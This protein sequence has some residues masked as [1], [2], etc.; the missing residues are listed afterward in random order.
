MTDENS[1]S[2]RYGY[3]CPNCN[4]RT[5]PYV[6][7]QNSPYLQNVLYASYEE[8]RQAPVANAEFYLCKTCLYLFNP[9]FNWNNIQYNDQ[10]NNDQNHSLAYCDHMD[11]VT[12]F[13]AQFIDL[14]ADIS[15]L[16]IGCGNG[17]LLS[18]LNERGVSNLKGYDPSYQG[19]FGMNKY[20]T[21]EYWKCQQNEYFDVIIIRHTLEGVEDPKALLGQIK[22]ASNTNT[23]LY[24]EITDL[25]TILR[26]GKLCNLYHE[27]ARYFSLTSVAFLLTKFGYQIHGMKY[28]FAGN[29]L[30]V[31]AKR[32]EENKLPR[33]EL[34][35][36]NR[37][38]RILIWGIGGMSI[39]FLT[40][41][42]ISSAKIRFGVDIDKTKQHKYIPFTGQ[43]ILS[44]AEAVEYH[45]D[46]VIVLNTIYANEV[47]DVFDYDVDVLTAKD[48][49][50]NTEGDRK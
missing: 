17:Y 8:A 44:P 20:I 12:N 4:S 22:Q 14:T 2:Y 36:L 33:A 13:I 7:I 25:S 37:Y 23:L 28:Y 5:V 30:G 41:Y 11:N 29:L 39:Q 42:G 9:S 40:H 15:V 43:R 45:P 10:Y 34:E 46:L 27:C 1:K 16:E 50:K 18:L 19:A 24:L 47:R 48:I 35:L 3:V 38:N 32:I 6:V 31:V 49:Y 21:R 26:E